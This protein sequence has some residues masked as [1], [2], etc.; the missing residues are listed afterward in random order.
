MTK[1][2]STPE[3][4]EGHRLEEVLT[5]IQTELVRRSNKIVVDPRNEARRVL[6]NNIEILGL[7]TKCI[8]LAEDSTRVVN[9][10]GLPRP[11]APPR[12]GEP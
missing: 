12:I 3:H 7:L 11:G 1:F 10:I 5:N 8:K 9:S 6:Q 4:P 2:F